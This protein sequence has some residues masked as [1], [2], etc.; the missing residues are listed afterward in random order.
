[1]VDKGDFRPRIAQATREFQAPLQPLAGEN[2][3]YF[4]TIAG[5]RAAGTGMQAMAA[6]EPYRL[7]DL[8]AK[9]H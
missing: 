5:A 8:H 1:M 3:S 2:S 7:Q 6:L 9:L 4:T